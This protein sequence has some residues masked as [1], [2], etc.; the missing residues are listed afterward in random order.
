MGSEMCIRDSPYSLTIRFEE[1]SRRYTLV[2][3]KDPR[4]ESVEYIHKDQMNYF[5]NKRV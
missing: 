3:E 2:E 1:E 4:V 5:V